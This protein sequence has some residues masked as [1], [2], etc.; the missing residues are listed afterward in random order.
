MRAVIDR[1]TAI[2]ELEGQAHPMKYATTS[3]AQVERFIARAV[4]PTRAVEAVPESVLLEALLEFVAPDDLADATAKAAVKRDGWLYAARHAPN[5]ELRTWYTHVANVVVQ[6]EV[7]RLHQQW[8]QRFEQL[9]AVLCSRGCLKGAMHLNRS[10]PPGQQLY[11]AYEPGPDY[12]AWNYH[13][14]DVVMMP[15]EATKNQGEAPA[16]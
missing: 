13:R 15:P 1:T 8:I 4:C 10:L 5:A 3:Q 6:A 2:F 9:L 16:A 7:E 11:R 14:D 12:T